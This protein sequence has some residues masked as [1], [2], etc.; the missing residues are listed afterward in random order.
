MILTGTEE[1][2]LKAIYSLSGSENSFISN[3]DIGNELDIK[4]SSV[5]DMIKKLGEKG[6]VEYKKYKGSKL[7]KEGVDIAIS[8]VRK[9]RL[10]EVFLVEKLKFGWDEVHDIAEQLE[11]VVSN[12]LTNRLDEFLG[13][14]KYD[15]H[16][17]A[18]P[19]KNGNVLHS[20]DLIDLK[21]LSLDTWGSIKGLNKSDDLFLSYLK[22]MGLILG[23][24][25]K[26]TEKFEFDGSALIEI[27]DSGK[28]NVS[29]KIL[30][31]LKVQI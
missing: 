6:F 31:N 8:I 28:L 7:S 30:E 26:I 21:D 19:D 12:D 16:G 5:T 17:D 14:P 1:N 10:W 27:Y 25:I 9:H 4:P 29:S 23:V 2:Y 24:K 20:S 13:F 22:K 18:I 3:N 11:H 15:P